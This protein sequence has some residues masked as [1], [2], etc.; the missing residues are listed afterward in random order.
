MQASSYISLSDSEKFG[1]QSINAGLYREMSFL[2]KYQSLCIDK[3]KQ[4]EKF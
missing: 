1:M 3:C 2:D 4:E